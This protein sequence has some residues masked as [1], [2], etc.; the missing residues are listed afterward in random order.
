MNKYLIL[1]AL[2][3]I[4]LFSC[5]ES[6][7]KSISTTTDPL[8]ELQFEVV[9]SI[10]VDV[11]E[12][13]V[14]LDYQDDLD[15]YLMKERRGGKIFIV[16]GNGEMIE[17]VALAGEGPNQ[18]SMIWEGRFLGKDRF[19]FTVVRLSLESKDKVL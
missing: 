12:D 19:I 8:Q 2:F 13:L 15:Q 7:K 5:S 14:I 9:D 11:L 16:N 4:L 6:E 10:M 3:A 18:V 1:T 17:E